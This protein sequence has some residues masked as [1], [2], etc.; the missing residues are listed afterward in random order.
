MGYD[1]GYK[2]FHVIIGTIKPFQRLQTYYLQY[3]KR[4][5][6]NVLYIE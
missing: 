3:L 4:I 2:K 1:S 5:I 6:R